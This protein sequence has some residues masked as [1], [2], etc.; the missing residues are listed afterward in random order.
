MAKYKYY[1]E[2]EHPSGE[3]VRM[4]FGEYGLEYGRGYIQRHR[5]EPGPSIGMRLVREDGKVM[6]E[7]PAKPDVS[8][9]MIAGFPT[10]SQYLRAAKRALLLSMRARGASRLVNGYT[11]D[12]IGYLDEALKFLEGEHETNKD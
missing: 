4:A 6:D 5:E 8:L 1:M 7:A 12:A 11:E 10:S 3:W 2:V 9:G